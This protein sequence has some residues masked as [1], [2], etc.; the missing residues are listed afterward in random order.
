MAPQAQRLKWPSFSLSRFAVG[1]GDVQNKS[2]KSGSGLLKDSKGEL[3]WE[4]EVVKHSACARHV[5]MAACSI[6]DLL[7]WE[8]PNPGRASEHVHHVLGLLYL[9]ERA[10]SKQ[11]LQSIPRA[12]RKAY[13][14]SQ[15]GIFCSRLP[16]HFANC[17]CQ[18][19]HRSSCCAGHLTG[20]T[21][22]S[23]QSG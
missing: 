17:P 9:P 14:G 6:A 5:T 16:A 1:R 8:L 2:M 21:H 4:S 18:F 15:A 12:S 3:A 20:Q 19:S 22:W 13:S 23:V 11:A 7:L 10:H